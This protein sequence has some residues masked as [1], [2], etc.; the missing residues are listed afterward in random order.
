M[1]CPA[2]LVYFDQADVLS[3]TLVNALTKVEESRAHPNELIRV[4]FKPSFWSE[5]ICVL[6]KDCFVSVYDNGRTADDYTVGH[7]KVTDLL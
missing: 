3:E 6:A 2:Y 5:D 1:S 7:F 4:C